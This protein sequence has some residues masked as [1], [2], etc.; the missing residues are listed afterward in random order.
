MIMLSEILYLCIDEGFSLI[1]LTVCVHQGP[2]GQRG[3]RGST[4]KPGAKVCLNLCPHRC[5]TG[6]IMI[7]I[8]IMILVVDDHVL[9]LLSLST[10]LSL[11]IH[12]DG[13]KTSK[14]DILI[15]LFNYL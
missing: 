4:G 14:L 7:M 15:F 11:Y 9:L 5:F 2:R 3:P 12:I 10:S 6:V 13:T 1:L 8:L